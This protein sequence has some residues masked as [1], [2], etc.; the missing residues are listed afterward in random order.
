VRRPSS[1][2][3]YFRPEVEPELGK[4]GVDGAGL[5]ADPLQDLLEGVHHL[6]EVRAARKAHKVLRAPGEVTEGSLWTTHGDSQD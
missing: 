1:L 4:E 2:P 6:H 3:R 5:D